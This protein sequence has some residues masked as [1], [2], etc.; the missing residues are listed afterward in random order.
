MAKQK[1]SKS[2]IKKV[3]AAKKKARAVKALKRH[4]AKPRASAR[5]LRAKLRAHA[6]KAASAKPGKPVAAK[7]DQKALKGAAAAKAGA[8]P[9]IKTTAKQALELLEAKV[10]QV[11]TKGK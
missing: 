4:V 11:K 6:R 8:K 1:R 7:V 9:Q 2:R 10:A 3:H 5:L